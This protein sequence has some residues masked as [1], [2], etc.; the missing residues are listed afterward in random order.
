MS[1]STHTGT[2]HELYLPTAYL[3][4]LEYMLYLFRARIVRIELHETWPKQTWRNRCSIMT[5]NGLLDLVVPVSK[6]SG[7]STITRDVDISDHESWHKR[8]WRAICAAYKNAPFFMYYSD[9]L[10]PFYTAPPS[11]KIWQFNKKLM[12]TLLDEIAIE[13]K[14]TETTAFKKEIDCPDLREELTPKLHRRRH[15]AAD[16]WPAYYQVF[17]DVHGFKPNL[18]I[19]DL[20][21][22]VGPDTKSYLEKA[23]E[24]NQ[25]Q[26]RLG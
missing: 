13:T 17:S 2:C 1:A 9:L 6:P 16:Q 10:E 7:N 15:P 19:I 3:P 4:P 22:H 20:L 23:A 5:A 26:L 24:M 8:H 25:H 12:Q 18:S 21:F 14:H 11:G